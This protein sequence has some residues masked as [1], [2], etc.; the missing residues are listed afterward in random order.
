MEDLFTETR[1]EVETLIKKLIV[2]NL[3]SLMLVSCQAILLGFLLDLKIAQL[4]VPV[5][6]NLHNLSVVIILDTAK[7]R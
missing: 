3:S 2:I 5:L 6:H 4:G 1:K 7:C